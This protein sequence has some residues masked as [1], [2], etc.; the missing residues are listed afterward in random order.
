MKV[1]SISTFVFTLFFLFA[2]CGRDTKLITIERP[3]ETS[4]TQQNINR[5]KI[6]VNN[7]VFNATLEDNPTA[8]AFQK[9]LP[10][11]LTMSDLNGNEKYV[12]LPKSLPTASINPGAIQT[13]DIMLFGNNT[14]VLFYDSFNTSYSYSKIGKIEQPNEFQS[15]LGDGNVLVKFESN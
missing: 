1:I 2:S 4:E 8:L 15:V 11:T 3:V 6:T 14:L 10:L 7:R 12:D 5:M 9:L 13:G